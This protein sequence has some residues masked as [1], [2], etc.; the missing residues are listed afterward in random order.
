MRIQSVRS[1]TVELSVPPANVNEVQA[2]NILT[3][4]DHAYFKQLRAKFH[5]RVHKLDQNDTPSDLRNNEL[6]DKRY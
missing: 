1:T 2:T 4:D 5:N 6:N 3:S